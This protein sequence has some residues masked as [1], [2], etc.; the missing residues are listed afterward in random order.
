MR[1]PVKSIHL[2]CRDQLNLH[3]V[4]GQKDVWTTGNWDLAPE[5][6]ESLVGGT[7]FLH[8]K[9]TKASYFG[10]KISGIKSVDT[11]NAKSRRIVFTFTYV[12]EARGA[13]WRGGTTPRAWTSGVIEEA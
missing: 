6:A 10:G 7:V 12:H 9:K 5:V 1:T 4:A 8:D 3:R 11:D 2:L 13:K